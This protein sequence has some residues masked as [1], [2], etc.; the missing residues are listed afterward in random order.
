MARR[1]AGRGEPL[2]DLQQV[3]RIGLIHAVDRYDPGR[4]S[5]T[6]F[7]QIT[8]CGEVKRHFRDKTWVCTS[9]GACE[10]CA[11]ICSTPP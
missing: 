1:Y 3:A 2:E 10:I 8:V 11:S 9:P 6:A 4:G 5:F 7:A